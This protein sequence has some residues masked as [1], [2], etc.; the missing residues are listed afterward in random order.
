MSISHF[1]FGFFAE[2]S[3]KT[4]LAI[5]IGVAACDAGFR[6]RF[7]RTATLVNALTKAKKQGVLSHFMRQF[8]KLCE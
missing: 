7:W 1:S 8:E 3:G 2:K 4:H 6:T 5:A